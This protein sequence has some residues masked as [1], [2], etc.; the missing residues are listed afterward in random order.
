MRQNRWHRYDVYH[1][2]LRSVDAAPPRLAVR[3]AAL[4]HDIDKPR[5]AAPSLK[6]PGETTFYN[7]EV[8]GAGRAKEIL[9]RLRFPGRLCDEVTLLVREHQFVYADDWSDGAV[10]RMLSR[11]GRASID[12]LLAV[13]EADIRGRG[14]YLEEG[15]EN[16]R[17]LERRVRTLEEKELALDVKDLALGGRDV[18]EALGEGPSPRIGEAMRWLLAR[19]LDEPACNT[20]EGLRALLAE[21]KNAAP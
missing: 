13:R 14:F 2:V 4:L 8:S 1:H 17:A 12:D 5:T 15:L 20:P 9:Q 3:L 10:R 21:W 18:M 7:H 11:V 19:V 16:V 6:A